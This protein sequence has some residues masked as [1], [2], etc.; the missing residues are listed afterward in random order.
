MPCPEAAGEQL[1]GVAEL[2]VELGRGACRPGSRARGAPP[3]APAGRRGS[4]AAG[5]ATTKPASAPTKAPA[6]TRT[7]KSAW[8]IRRPAFS[9]VSRL[10]SRTFRCAK[11]PSTRCTAEPANRVSCESGWFWTGLAPVQRHARP[12]AGRAARSR[13]GQH[14][15]EQQP[16]SDGQQGHGRLT[17]VRLRSAGRQTRRG[18]RGCPDPRSGQ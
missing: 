15:R 1:E 16:D 2:L 7:K 11:N 6:S 8:L 13:A 9:R 10:K 3:A 17:S 18:R 14:R 5:P 4:P 12:A